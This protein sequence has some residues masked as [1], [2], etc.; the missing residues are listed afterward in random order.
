M[1][2]DT[3]LH[4]TFTAFLTLSPNPIP[5]SH[6]FCFL[7]PG[8]GIYLKGGSLIKPPKEPAYSNGF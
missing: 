2:F 8:L 5:L 4:S 7:A 3:S 6:F 1:W